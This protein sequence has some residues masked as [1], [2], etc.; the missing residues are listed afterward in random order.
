MIVW[1][2]F[3]TAISPLKKGSGGPKFLDFLIHYELSDYQYFLFFTV[4]LGDLEGV[5][6]INPQLK[7]LQLRPTVRVNPIILFPSLIKEDVERLMLA[8]TD[9]RRLEAQT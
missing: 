5:G 3:H 1:H 9:Y 2:F 7:I 4:I 8:T 6:T